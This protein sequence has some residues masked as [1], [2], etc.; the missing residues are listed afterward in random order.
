METETAKLQQEIKLL[1]HSMN[2]KER[3]AQVAYKSK[4]QSHE[5]DI[6]KAAQ[7]KVMI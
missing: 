4:E 2:Q 5:E 3:E 1:T 6:S 7:Q